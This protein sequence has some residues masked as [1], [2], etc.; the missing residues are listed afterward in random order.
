MAGDAGGEAEGAAAVAAVAVDDLRRGGLE[1]NELIRLR[2]RSLG[3][4]GA[5]YHV[6][7]CW[8]RTNE[9]HT[10]GMQNVMMVSRTV[11]RSSRN[12]AFWGWFTT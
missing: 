3:S 8:A 12:L 6:W 7:T 9:G 1:G 4:Q 10:T 11:F 2:S 5:I